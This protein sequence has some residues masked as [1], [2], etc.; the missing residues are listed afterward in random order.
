MK[1]QFGRNIDYLRISITDRCNLRC[2]YCMPEE[3]PFISHNDILRYEEI[4][5]ICELLVTVGINTVRVTGGEPLIRKGCIDF[6]GMLKEIP[7]I[8]HVSLTTNAVLLEPELEKLRK[9]NLDS[10]NISLDSLN[11]DTYKRITGQDYLERVLKAI[12]T[13]T[14]LGLQVKINCVPIIGVNDSE[15]VEVARLAEKYP[16]HV[17][18]IELM[19]TSQNR[20]LHGV[21]ANEI[22]KT[23]S[24]VYEDLSNDQIKH[25]FG[26]AKYFTGS[27]LKGSLGIINAVSDHF[28]SECN[29]LRL[30]SDGFLKLCL[31]HDDGLDLRDMIRSG[32]SDN[33][34]ITAIKNSI[35]NKPLRHHFEKETEENSGI[36]KM[37]R[38]GG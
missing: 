38:I 21:T 36:K 25:G 18:F 22:L 19:P 30:T 24:E 28:C 14:K 8:E 29:R 37:S 12:Y 26:P 27:E 32:E 17:R 5:R 9:M 34:I 31:Y 3:L 11:S 1:D 6:L 13:A 33:E 15:I 4:L 35:F 2:E 16:V 23:L 7:G 10:I 20:G